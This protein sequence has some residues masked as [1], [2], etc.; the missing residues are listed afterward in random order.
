MWK[1]T[2]PGKIK[3]CVWRACSD[4]LP[5]RV[6]LETKGVVVDKICF[7]FVVPIRSWR[8]MFSK[9]VHLLVRVRIFSIKNGV[10]APGASFNV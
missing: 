3:M 8:Y 2:I 4:I 5:T 9:I 10:K 7:F 1:A 6:N